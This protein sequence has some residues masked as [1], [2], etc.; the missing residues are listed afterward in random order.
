[1]LIEI[2]S[3]NNEHDKKKVLDYIEYFE[4]KG[5]SVHTNFYYR[6]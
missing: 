6:G 2:I 3:T 1:M 4:K 5:I